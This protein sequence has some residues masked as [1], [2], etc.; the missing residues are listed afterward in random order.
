MAGPSPVDLLDQRCRPE[1][2]RQLLGGIA[3]AAR[4]RSDVGGGEW[5]VESRGKKA[6]EVV[7][8]G[9]V[10]DVDDLLDVAIDC[11]VAT[12][13]AAQRGVV[14]LLAGLVEE[15]HV[16]RQVGVVEERGDAD[17]FVEERIDRPSLR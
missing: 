4:G 8:R 6:A 14:D 13:S 1:A 10:L 5:L 7:D 17:E 3:S 9:E 2:V 16:E 11:A 12:P 15:H